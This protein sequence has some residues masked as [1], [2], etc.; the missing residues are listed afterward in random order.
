[1][2]KMSLTRAFVQAETAS[3]GAE[4]IKP[5]TLP[6]SVPL[7]CLVP[8]NNLVVD[9]VNVEFDMEITAVAPKEQKP[10][11]AGINPVVN[12]KAVLLGK[13]SHRAST[14]RDGRATQVSSNLKVN[15]NAGPLPLPLGLLTILELYSKSIGPEVPKTKT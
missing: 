6:F 5:F 9:K 1:M 11:L 12:D 14:V 7:I 10:L 3:L 4:S 8:I 15:I 2:I 13:I